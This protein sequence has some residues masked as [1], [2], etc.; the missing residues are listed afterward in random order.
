[1]PH[2]SV[3]Q[4]YRKSE[5]DEKEATMKQFYV[6]PRIYCTKENLDTVLAGTTKALIV[7]DHFMHEN[8]MDEYLTVPMMQ[9]GIEY[10]IFA[11]VTGEP[12]MEMVAEG[13]NILAE[14]QPDTVYG[15]GGG[16]AIDAAK[17][18]CYLLAKHQGKTNRRFVAIPTTS[19]TGT[20]V[21]SYA[22][23]TDEKEATKYPIHDDEMLPDM[24]LLDAELCVTVPPSVTAD[25]GI[26]V[27]THAIEA[28][29]TGTA[30]DFTDAAA[31]KAARLVYENL[32][33]VY[34]NPSDLA[35]RQKVHDASCLAGI[36]F[37]NSGLGLNHGMAHALGS[38]F[39]IPHGRANAVLL[40]YVM[41][42][43]AGCH[44]SL[45]PIACR[46]AELAKVLSLSSSSVRAS[47]LNLIRSLRQYILRLN[48]PDRICNLGIS[49][50]EFDAVLDEMVESALNDACTAGNPRIPTAED[51]REL[52]ITAYLGRQVNI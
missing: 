38:H 19:G 21:S 16:S 36:A 9:K 40:P 28:Y 15:F 25:A 14:F 29:V 3:E 27:L 5:K 45:T 39:H 26:D 46:Y 51:V 2:F 6:R 7:T 33:Q 4:L 32:H 42:Y 17:A 18:M 52:Y 12:N 50:E 13:V 34:K 8:K 49:R 43:N 23:I 41:A 24:V 20:E 10:R 47:C 1:M 11:G 22:V 31:E 30:D 37:N 44:D 35:A 48:I